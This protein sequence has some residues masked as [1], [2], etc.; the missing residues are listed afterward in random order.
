MKGV[1]GVYTI[2][3]DLAVYVY[4]INYGIEDEIEW[5]LS[6]DAENIQTSK[7]EYDYEDD[8][9]PL[10][11]ARPFFMQGDRKIYLDE[12]IRTDLTESVEKLEEET[13]AKLDQNVK[14]W[15][16]QEYPEEEDFLVDMDDTLT[17]KDVYDRM[18]NGEEIYEITNIGDSTDREYIFN[19]LSEATG[20][21]YEYFYQLWVHGPTSSEFLKEVIK[22]NNGEVTDDIIESAIK[23]YLDDSNGIFTDDSAYTVADSLVGLDTMGNSDEEMVKRIR[24]ILHKKFKPVEEN[25]TEAEE[26][27]EE[28]KT[29][30]K[31]YIYQIAK[32]DYDVG[33]PIDSDDFDLFKS[34]MEEDNFKLTDEEYEKA[35]D[36]YWECY[37]EIREK[38][39]DD[40][41]KDYE[42]PKDYKKD[43]SFYN[44]E[45]DSLV[46]QGL[47]VNEIITDICDGWLGS[48]Y[49]ARCRY[50][51]KYLKSK[52]N[53]INYTDRYK[54]PEKV[55]YSQ[56]KKKIDSLVNQGLTRDEIEDIICKPYVGK[57]IC[58]EVL[59]YIYEYLENEYKMIYS[60]DVYVK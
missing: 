45:I 23:G 43:Y 54:E 36:Y 56:I 49:T 16:L 6:N 4:N 38:E 29:N 30:W 27:K 37:N 9:G 58:K 21:D 3:N 25:L 2:S 40:Y 18:L 46:N 15:L 12:V 8:E 19:G 42:D 20:K 5:A 26:I 35:W 34:Y 41:D 22:E 47:T 10:D 13:K 51:S 44:N 31:S 1:K 53:M 32:D 7:I 48:A 24:D 52:Y 14:E 59:T 28:V 55:N 39:F 11:E 33:H 50:I 60:N 17:F 57:Y